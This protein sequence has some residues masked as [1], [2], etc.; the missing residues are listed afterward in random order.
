M[1]TAASCVLNPDTN[2]FYSAEELS[3]AM[4]SL[5]R[6]DNAFYTHKTPVLNV[7]PHGRFNRRTLANNLAL[8]VVGFQVVKL[9]SPLTILFLVSFRVTQMFIDNRLKDS[10]LSFRL[11]LLRCSL[12]VRS[13][14][15]AQTVTFLAGERN[16]LVKLKVALS[17]K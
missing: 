15:K 3:V 16:W 14:K 11:R 7:K 4:G 10:S 1:L 17:L 8:L 13:F 9:K 12:P 2:E 5:G 6:S